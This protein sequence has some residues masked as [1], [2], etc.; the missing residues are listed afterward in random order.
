M[1]GG[2]GE[3]SREK[4]PHK[5]VRIDSKLPG[6]GV[7]SGTLSLPYLLSMRMSKFIDKDGTALTYVTKLPA[8]ELDIVVAAPDGASV[9]FRADAATLRALGEKFS[10]MADKAERFGKAGH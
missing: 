1:H 8:F 7:S 2:E 5:P 9:T 10:S 4:R 3:A 6:A